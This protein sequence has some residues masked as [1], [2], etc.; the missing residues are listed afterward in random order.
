MTVDTR[1]FLS[2]FSAVLARASQVS[3]PSTTA[4]PG[5]LPSISSMTWDM[6]VNMP[7]GMIKV[8]EL[9]TRCVK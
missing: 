8:L 9:V 2:S 3:S 5:V 6:A 1:D 4:V 7:F